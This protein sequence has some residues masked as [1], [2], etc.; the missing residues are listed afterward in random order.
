MRKEDFVMEADLV[1][2]GRE[3]QTQRDKKKLS[4]NG[5]DN[6]REVRLMPYVDESVVLRMV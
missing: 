3:N 6:S 4:G 5:V 1:D 2:A